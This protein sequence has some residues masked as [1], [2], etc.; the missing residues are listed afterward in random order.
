VS[1]ARAWNE[2]EAHNIVKRHAGREG[3]LLPILHD[4]QATFGCVS[5]T[6]V[7]LVAAALNLGRA[8]VHGPARR[9]VGGAVAAAQ[10]QRCRSHAMVGRREIKE[11]EVA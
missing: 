1:I 4:I 7:R 5:P 2:A 6:A 9:R 3:A 10:R 8:A 11:L